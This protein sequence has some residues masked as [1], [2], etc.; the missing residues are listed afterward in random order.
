MPRVINRISRIEMKG[1]TRRKTNI[2]KFTLCFFEDAFPEYKSEEK[3]EM[4]K[5]KKR[6]RGRC[7]SQFIVTRTPHTANERNKKKYI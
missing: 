1:E 2:Q 7:S 4:K 3:E 5:K 6:R